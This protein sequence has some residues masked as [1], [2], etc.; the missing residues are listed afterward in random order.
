MRHSLAS[1]MNESSTEWKMIMMR[2]PK[3]LLA[4]SLTAFAVGI[5]VTLGTPNIPLGWTAVMPLGAVFLGL[6]LV[7]FLLQK[8][9]ARFD[10]EEHA[11]LE[12]A[13]RY[14]AKAPDAAADAFSTGTNLTPAHSH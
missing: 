12:L 11:R 2:I 10:D 4:V 8:E 14:A 6:F 13:E 1:L 3:V 7:T 9:V 5:V